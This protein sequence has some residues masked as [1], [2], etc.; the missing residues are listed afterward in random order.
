MLAYCC[1]WQKTICLWIFD[2]DVI[3]NI[4][5][6]R[7]CYAAHTALTTFV[8]NWAEVMRNRQAHTPHKPDT[9]CWLI[10]L[11]VLMVLIYSLHVA[12]HITL[13]LLVSN[14]YIYIYTHTH[15][16]IRIFIPWVSVKNVFIMV[17]CNGKHSEGTGLLVTVKRV[18]VR[19]KDDFKMLIQV[20]CWH[21]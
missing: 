12:N 4:R 15:M 18:C 1:H 3:E 16:Y 7:T 10:I 20:H 13:F 8:P 21:Y 9:K 19:E 6:R 17:G 11:F 2:I 5:K 14:I